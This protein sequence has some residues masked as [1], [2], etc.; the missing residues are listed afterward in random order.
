MIR[1]KNLKHSFFL[2]QHIKYI[3]RTNKMYVYKSQGAN[4]INNFRF[5]DM[6]ENEIIFIPNKKSEGITI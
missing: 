6:I 3:Y 1:P 2:D 4:G 5:D